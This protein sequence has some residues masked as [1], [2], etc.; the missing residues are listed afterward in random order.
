V[1][2]AEPIMEL[3]T[4]ESVPET[5][6]GKEVW[7]LEE[8]P[9]CSE[10]VRRPADSPPGARPLRGR[11]V[12]RELPS[13]EAVPPAY[14]SYRPPMLSELQD[15]A[16][17]LGAEEEPAEAIEPVAENPEA[18]HYF[19]GEAGW[20]PIQVMEMEM[21]LEL[22][23][24][25]HA[26]GYYAVVQSGEGFELGPPVP[27]SYVYEVPPPEPI[28]PAPAPAEDPGSQESESRSSPT[29][30]ASAWSEPPPSAYGLESKKEEQKGSSS[31]DERKENHAPARQLV[32]GKRPEQGRQASPGP[33]GKARRGK[34]HA[35]RSMEM[36]QKP[37]KP[38]KEN[39]KQNIFLFAPSKPTFTTVAAASSESWNRPGNKVYAPEPPRN[40]E[41]PR[42][43][44]PSRRTAGSDVGSMDWATK[45]SQRD[46]FA[47]ADSKNSSAKMAAEWTAD[48]GRPWTQSSDARPSTQ[49][50]ADPGRPWTQSTDVGTRGV[51]TADTIPGG[52]AGM[53][54]IPPG[55]DSD[56]DEEEAARREIAEVENE[57]ELYPFAQ[58]ASGGGARSLRV[59]QGVRR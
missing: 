5:N 58:P 53:G 36:E 39:A 40:A 49:S 6:Y 34:D 23:Q 26:C 14:Q 52:A 3:A 45:P 43:R 1:P 25:G 19:F 35:N 20:Q 12:Q 11:A 4:L 16:E 21:P 17:P 30:T 47:W 41:Q 37:P 9:I 55:L 57:F 24:Q 29:G 10:A 7:A 54:V 33:R 27:H 31:V 38:R 28:Q 22:A 15:S 13:P 48:P 51:S 44:R 42:F 56:S 46:A 32:R 8:V 50:T 18:T 59:L 2:P